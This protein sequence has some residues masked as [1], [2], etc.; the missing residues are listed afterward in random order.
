[1]EQAAILISGYCDES[2]SQEELET[3]RHWL[4]EDS[5]HIDRFARDLLLNS[6]LVDLLQEQRLQFDAWSDALEGDHPAVDNQPDK[7]TV[8]APRPTSAGLKRWMI[9][10]A[11]IAS[12]LAVTVLVLI[13]P[14]GSHVVAQASSVAGAAVKSDGT[15]VLAGAFL[16]EGERL[17]VDRG[18]L[19]LTFGCG[20]KVLLE[21]PAVF[22][23]NSRTTGTL[24]RGVAAAHVPTQ[25][26]GFAVN[27][28]LVKVVDLGTEFRLK[29]LNDDQLELHVFDGLVDVHLGERFDQAHFGPLKI[30]EGR[31]IRFDAATSTILTLDFDNGLR[32]KF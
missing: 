21:A 19:I 5:A 3:L 10:V 27:T 4:R 29:L 23:L 25:A 9:S 26:I 32:S 13:Q 12:A 20:A 1:M 22:I 28:P 2:L 17:R 18:N 6:R 14:W 24:S 11:T 31:S 7:S 8:A 15:K 16:P 30:S